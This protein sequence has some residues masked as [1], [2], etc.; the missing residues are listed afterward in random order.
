M[1][2]EKAFRDPW[3]FQPFLRFYKFIVTDPEVAD[4]L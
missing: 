2:F 3:W 1:A 4:K